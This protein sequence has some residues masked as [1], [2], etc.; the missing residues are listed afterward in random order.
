MLSGAPEHGAVRGAH[1][2]ACPT[3]HNAMRIARCSM[4]YPSAPKS[5]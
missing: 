4:P 3:V 5:V 1:A 2:A